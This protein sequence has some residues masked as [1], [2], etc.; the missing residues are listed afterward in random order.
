M[1]VE[2][3]T[4]EQAG[5]YGRYTNEPTDAQL[6]RYFYP[7][8]ADRPL[9][10]QRRGDHNRLGFALQLCTVRFLGT[11]LADP[12]DVPPRVVAYV[13][14]QLRIA[15]P[16]CLV[17]YLERPATH[18]EH[19]GE[20]QRRYDYRDFTEQPG[21]FRLVRWLYTRAWFQAERP[22]V[23]FD[24]ATGRLV[25]QKI[26]LPGVSQ[27]ARLIARVRER[28]AHRLWQTL[29]RLPSSAQRDNLDALLVVPESARY[30]L[31]V[32]QSLEPK[33]TLSCHFILTHRISFSEVVR[34]RAPRVSCVHLLRLP[35]LVKDALPSRR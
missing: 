6:S 4:D 25:E 13:C 1:P 28:A 3:L 15:D 21:H 16:G 2:F 31:G 8:D 29:A 11:F 22:S 7:D 32:C 10:V 23:L 5:Q 24:L 14:R 9:I 20:I 30:S 19:A 12:T 17:R 33:R 18:R 34:P 26:L 27:L 35:G